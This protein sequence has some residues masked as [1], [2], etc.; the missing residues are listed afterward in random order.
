MKREIKAKQAL[1]D[2][3][4]GMDDL[5]LMEKYKITDKG[6]RSLFRK[7]MSAGLLTQREVDGRD[8]TFVST[9]TLDLEDLGPGR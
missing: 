8:A 7:L 6:L 5:T 4:S 3:R 2:I 1:T 9:I